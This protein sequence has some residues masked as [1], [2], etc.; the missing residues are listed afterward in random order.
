MNHTRKMVLTPAQNGDGDDIFGAGVETASMPSEAAYVT[1][2]TS[3][4]ENPIRKYAADRQ[5]KL[6]SVVLK[7]ASC[8]G[9]DETGRIRGPHG[10]VIESSDI[11][12]L[13]L[14]ALSPGRTI[15]G[16]EAFVDL[17]A[18]ARVNPDDIINANVRAL[19]MKR[20]ARVTYPQAERPHVHRQPA[21]VVEEELMSPEI[22]P[23]PPLRL[24]VPTNDPRIT[25][26]KRKHVE[27]EEDDEEEVPSKRPL[28]D[29][30]DE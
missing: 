5:R 30:S 15:H 9:Y 28:W 16:L 14:H 21:E 18:R 24:M 17:L 22:P 8:D 7:I 20:A 10:E 25:R 27:E 4:K 6:L 23:P 29:T 2:T 13:L 12:S 3:K 11:I 26:G 19:L 1:K